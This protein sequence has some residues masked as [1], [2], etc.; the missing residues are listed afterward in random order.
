[1]NVKELMKKVETGDLESYVILAECYWSG[2]G[3]KK[4]KTKAKELLDE[5]AQKGSGECAYRL[6]M[7][8]E[9]GLSVDQSYETAR[10]YFMLAARNHH[11]VGTY[12]L[13]YY[14]QYGYGI[15]KDQ[16]EAKKYYQQAKE[17]GY[18]E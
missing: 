8:Y 15:Y 11:P 3:V 17:L 14:Y 2:D 12:K 10:S 16:D 4:S 5:G 13:A 1:M 6:G 7:L 9:K 18:Q